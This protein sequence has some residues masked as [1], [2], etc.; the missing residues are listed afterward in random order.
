MIF[1]EFIKR[2]LL[3]SHTG[4]T[5]EPGRRFRRKREIPDLHQRATR[6]PEKIFQAGLNRLADSSE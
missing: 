1:I 6:T 2:R 5:A 3:R 4:S